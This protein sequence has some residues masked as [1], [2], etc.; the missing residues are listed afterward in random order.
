[1]P[2]CP[3]IDV[4]EKMECSRAY[5]F[6]TDQQNVLVFQYVHLLNKLEPNQRTLELKGSKKD[7]RMNLS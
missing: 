4:E 3:S 5:L 7:S 2:F 6:R 1:M